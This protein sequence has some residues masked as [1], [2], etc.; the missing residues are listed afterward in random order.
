MPPVNAVA[1]SLKVRPFQSANL[2]FEVGGVIGE[3]NAN[4]AVARGAAPS[5]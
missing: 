1:I 3:H 4:L 2:C 5:L